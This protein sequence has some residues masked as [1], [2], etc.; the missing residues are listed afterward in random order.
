MPARQAL[1]V[2]GNPLA[3]C[4]LQGGPVTGFYRDGMC[5]T[6]DQDTGKHTVAGIVSDQF[7]KFSKARGN[8]LSTPRPNFPGLKAGDRW[9]LCSDRWLESYQ[10]REQEGEGVVPK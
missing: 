4:S 5:N 6:S 8:D 1:N 2:L 9:C 3:P 10:A 7:L